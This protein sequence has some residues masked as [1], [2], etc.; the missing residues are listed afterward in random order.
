MTEV[1]AVWPRICIKGLVLVAEVLTECDATETV[2]I[3]SYSKSRSVL[4]CF[5]CYLAV[6]K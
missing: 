2:I 4:N 6:T 1:S 3:V 5:L